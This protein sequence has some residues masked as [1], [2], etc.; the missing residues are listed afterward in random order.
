MKL[1]S[2]YLKNAWLVA[3]E[4][5]NELQFGLI[6]PGDTATDAEEAKRR[7]VYILER[8]AARVVGTPIRADSL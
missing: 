8:T 3:I 4:D 6:V 5:D 1:K 7:A 2:D